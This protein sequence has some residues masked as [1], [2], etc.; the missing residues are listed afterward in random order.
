MRNNYSF[1]HHRNLNTFRKMHY[2][3]RNL[4]LILTANKECFSLPKSKYLCSCVSHKWIVMLCIQSSWNLFENFLSEKQK[5]NSAKTSNRYSAT[6]C[7]NSVNECVLSLKMS[8]PF[9]IAMHSFLI[10]YNK[11]YKKLPEH[12]IN[13]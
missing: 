11:N 9:I 4:L 5:F 12:V 6:F 8:K 13:K 10:R 7:V 2:S 3:K 1:D